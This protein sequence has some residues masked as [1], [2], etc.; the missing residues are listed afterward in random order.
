MAGSKAASKRPPPS[1][2]EPAPR[3]AAKPP[4]LDAKTLGLRVGIPVA[5]AWVIAVFIRHWIAYVVVGV[6]T[7]AALGLIWYALNFTKKTQRVQ[8]IVGGAKTKEERAAAIEQIDAEFK[9]GDSAGIFAKAQLQMQEDPELALRTLETIDLSKVMPAVADEARGQRA[10]LHLMLGQPKD[11][12]VLVDAIDLSRHS[13]QKAKATLASVI[14]EAWAR[15]GQAKRAVE[16][17]ELFDVEDPVLVDVKPG[18]LRARVFAF[19]GI[20]DLK[21]AR[22]AM[23]QLAK[24]DARIVAGFAQKGVHPLLVKEAKR[25]LERSGVMPRVTV[26]GPMR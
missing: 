8:S 10:M 17:L 7:A 15:S 2:E 22:T 19:G 16:I 1:R 18:L 3:A 9:K 24:I 23:H 13:D 20:D 5:I 12:R 11:A 25:I 14:C 26:R 21:S 6:L 4:Q